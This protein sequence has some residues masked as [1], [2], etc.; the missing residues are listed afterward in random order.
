MMKLRLP[1]QRHFSWKQVSLKD[2]WQNW[3]EEVR[4]WVEWKKKTW[5]STN[6]KWSCNFFIAS[7]SV[8]VFYDFISEDSVQKKFENGKTIKFECRLS[9]LQSSNTE[10]KKSLPVCSIVMF[11]VNVCV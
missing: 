10:G 6:R 5:F 2:I 1:I 8:Q 4:S 3:F 7:P 9:T 11:V